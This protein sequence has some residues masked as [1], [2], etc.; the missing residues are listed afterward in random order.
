MSALDAVYA[1]DAR[2]LSR[3][4][5]KVLGKYLDDTRLKPT[6]GARFRPPYH[7]KH[8]AMVVDNPCAEIFA[9]ISS[10]QSLD[11]GAGHPRMEGAARCPNEDVV[12]EI[13]HRGRTMLAA[14][15][16]I[17]FRCL[18]RFHNDGSVEPI[19]LRE[20]VAQ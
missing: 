3:L 5:R 9:R 19:L 12:A 13:V 11:R 7:L 16:A 10:P 18:P 8:L 14:L 2:Q 4:L 17:D 6:A 1:A 15:S 20:L